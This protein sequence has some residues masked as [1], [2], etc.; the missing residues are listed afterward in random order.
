MSQSSSVKGDLTNALE[1]CLVTLE[2]LYKLFICSDVFRGTS[3]AA[4][5]LGKFFRLILNC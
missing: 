1:A 4:K 3:A 5:V 2:L